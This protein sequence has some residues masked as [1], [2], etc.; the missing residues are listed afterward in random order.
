MA[1]EHP[2]AQQIEQAKTRFTSG[3]D[4]QDGFR[5][6]RQTWNELRKRQL[7]VVLP[8]EV[9]KGD[10]YFQYKTPELEKACFDWI[11]IGTTNPTM[12]DVV[13]IDQSSEAK[14]DARSVL[15][16]SAHGWELENEARTWDAAVIEGQVKDGL[17][18]M[19]LCCREQK[20]IKGDAKTKRKRQR[21]PFYWQDCD[22]FGVGWLGDETQEGGP[23]FAFYESEIPYLEAKSKYRK[24][25]K[26]LAWKG[27]K[28]GWYGQDE[29]VDKSNFPHQTV[30]VTTVDCLDPNGEMC[31]LDGCEHV[32]R[33]IYVFIC[34]PDEDI[35]DGYLFEEYDSPFPGCS[36]FVI[37]GRRSSD[38]DMD[39]RFRPMIAP[40]YVEGEATNY[41]STLLYAQIREDYG[42]SGYYIDYS[43]ADPRVLPEDGSMTFEF[44]GA[45]EGEI[46]GFP[47]DVKRMPRTLSPHL[48]QEI[49][50]HQQRMQEFMP[51]RFLTGSAYTEASNATGTAFLAQQ[52]QA[53]L[54]ANG[55][56]QK[57]DAAILKSRTYE[58]H[59]IQYWGLAGETEWYAVMSGNNRNV[60]IRGEQPKHAEVFTVTA[61]ML[62]NLDFDLRIFTNSETLAEQQ[63]RYQLARQKYMDGTITPDQFLREAGVDDIEGQKQQLRAAETY[64]LMVPEVQAAK[65]AAIT[66]IYKVLGGID[67][68]P[69]PAMGGMPG[70]PNPVNAAGGLGGT[71]HF[72]QPPG[73]MEG[74]QQNA[75]QDLQQTLVGAGAGNVS[76]GASPMGV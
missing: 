22:I 12:F 64:G 57:S 49:A 68:M 20:V 27:G 38:R 61:S 5:E 30:K 18:V 59:A 9:V 63:T 34:G 69:A 66:K 40:M 67:L 32:A 35:D 7:K 2:L 47:G 4:E 62:E 76:G 13:P 56:L 19:R 11:D 53:S 24:E 45:S 72:Q 36:F 1:S 43:Q 71:T 75:T 21:H 23:S 41:L 42:P 44:H 58:Y 74:Q 39:A 46:Q 14:E 17:K 3:S 60:T 28:C 65:K 10:D 54:P 15:M 52:Q 25:G 70:A 31:P 16:W 37:P 8:E 29:A 33:K 48:P 26:Q 6:K 51:N 73:F 50:I 55:L